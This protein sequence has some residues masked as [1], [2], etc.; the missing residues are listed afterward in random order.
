VACH[1]NNGRG[2]VFSQHKRVDRSNIFKLSIS[3]NQGDPTYGDQINIHGVF[4]VPE[5]AQPQINY[6]RVVITYPDGEQVSLQKPFLYLNQ[7]NYGN[8]HKKTLISA[9]IAPALT[10][11]GLIE[12]ISNEQILSYEDINDK[13]NDG[14]S[15]KANRLGYNSKNNQLILGKFTWKGAAG[16]VKNQ[17]ANAASNDMGLTNPLFPTEKCTQKQTECNKLAKSNTDLDLTNARLN[18]IAFYLKNLPLPKTKKVITKNKQIF[19]QLGCHACHRPSYQVNNQTIHPY[20]DFLL[21]DMGSELA[22]GHKEFDALSF[23][24]KTPP[25]WGIEKSAKL[26][27]A[28]KNYLHDG[29]ARTVEEAILWHA[30]EATKAKSAFMSLS[31]ND[32]TKLIQFIEHL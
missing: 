32:R 19:Y 22:D 30:G 4:G 25:L 18:A 2:H 23:E 20:S 13:N 9:R 5:E 1:K 6:Q 21:H 31:K 29:R 3:K 11:L 16:T 12:K 7:L 24:W 15:G 17:T 8:L 27:Q 28:N 26:L 10:G 14:I